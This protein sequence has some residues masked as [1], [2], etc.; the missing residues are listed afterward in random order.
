MREIK[1][2]AYSSMSNSILYFTL[3][4]VHHKHGEIL[5]IHGEIAE[6]LEIM[7]FTGIK[8]KNGKDIYEGDIIKDLNGTTHFSDNDYS[9]SFEVRYCI[10]K[11]RVGYNLD[12]KKRKRYKIIGNIFENKELLR[13][14]K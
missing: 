7:Q 3:A 4:D 12:Y 9:F 1:F 5:N 14:G 13:E 10:T 11:A 2:R 6:C 8:D